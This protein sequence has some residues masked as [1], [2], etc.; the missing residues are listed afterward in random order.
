MAASYLVEASDRPLADE[1]RFDAIGIV[2]DARG[3]MVSLEHLVA[4]F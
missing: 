1:L 2:F 4:A 3:Q